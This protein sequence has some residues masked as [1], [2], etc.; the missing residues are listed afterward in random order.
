MEKPL[1]TVDRALLLAHV[2]IFFL[3][4]AAIAYR[5]RECIALKVL[6]IYKLYKVFN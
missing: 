3:C 1:I 4:C 5:E 2:F 6:G